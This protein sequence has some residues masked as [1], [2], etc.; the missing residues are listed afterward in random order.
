MKGFMAQTVSKEKL[1][2]PLALR[3]MEAIDGSERN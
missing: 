2:H 1:V 3:T